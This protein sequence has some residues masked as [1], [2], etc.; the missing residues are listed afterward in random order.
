VPKTCATWA[1]ALR[2]YQQPAVKS[3]VKGYDGVWNPTGRDTDPIFERDT[4][5]RHRRVA[6]IRFLY[7]SADC[8]V[9]SA[10]VREDRR[11]PGIARAMVTAGPGTR[12]ALPPRG[13]LSRYGYVIAVGD[14]A[15][16][17]AAELADSASLIE[18]R[19]RPLPG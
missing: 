2:D 10:V 4:V 19:S 14:D 17:V 5:P 6:A 3:Q 12:L 16:L 7:P 9:I 18:L 15:A 11:G 13:Y 8:E 1:D